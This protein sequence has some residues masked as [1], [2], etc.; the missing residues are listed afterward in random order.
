MLSF[1]VPG[2]APAKVVIIGGGVVGENAAYMAIGL[3]ADVTILD[4]NIQ[5]LRDL[6]VRF[7]PSVN[8]I[9]STSLAI[10]EQVLAADLVIGGVLVK[11]AEAPKLVSEDLVR[12]MKGGSV[13]VDVAIDQGGCFETSHATTHSSHATHSSHIWH[14]TTATATM[15]VMVITTLFFVFLRNFC[16]QGR[17]CNQQRRDAG[18]VLDRG[19][20]HFGRVNDASRDQVAVGVFVCV[21]AF[22]LVLQLPHAINNYSTVLTGIVGDRSQWLIKDFLDDC[23]ADLNIAFELKSVDGFFSSDQRHATTG[24]HTRFQRRLRCGLGIF[25]ERFAFFHF[26]FGC[27]PTTDLGHAAGEFRQSLLQLLTIIFA[28]GVFDL[29]A[30]LLDPSLNCLFLTASTDDDG[31]L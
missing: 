19:A 21:V 14:A 5:T 18:R 30:D 29:V 12:R 17:G 3:G 20:N 22:G 2:V 7:G 6:V 10:E 27:R 23:S 11:G 16:D 13:L 31:L 25:D 24:D 8:T 28:I 15:M 4:R 26:G 9:Y 1:T